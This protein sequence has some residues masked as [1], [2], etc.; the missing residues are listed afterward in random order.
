[1]RLVGETAVEVLARQHR[2]LEKNFDLVRAPEEDHRAVWRRTTKLMSAHIAIERSYVYPIVR[3]E[4]LGSE[5][6]EGLLRHEYRSMEHL[7]LMTERRK[8]NSPDM[9]DLIAKLFDE[10]EEHVARCENEVVPALGQALGGEQLDEL[11]AKMAAAESVITSHP[12]PY[13]LALGPLY[14]VTTRMASK[15]DRVR[16]QLNHDW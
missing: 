14:R 10:F 4:R 16:D 8:M 11:G 9:P 6:L 13:L 12:H 3:H 15:F 2:Q 5:D 7:I 1:M